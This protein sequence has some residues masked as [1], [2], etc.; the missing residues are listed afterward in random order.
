MKVLCSQRFVSSHI[1]GEQ[2]SRA[3]DRV[4]A[5]PSLGIE[6]RP[7][8]SPVNYGFRTTQ[9][10]VE[11]KIPKNIFF[12]IVDS[13]HNEVN[14]K[15]FTNLSYEARQLRKNLRRLTLDDAAIWELEKKTPVSAPWAVMTL[16]LG[17]CNILDA[18]YTGQPIQRFWFLETIAR[19]PYFSYVAV[20]HLYETLGFW[21]LDSEVK[22]LHVAEETNEC[23]HLM[24]MESLGGGRRWRDRFLARHIGMSYFV[25]LVILFLLAPKLAYKCSELLE[26][27]AVN[28]YE[29]FLIENEELLKTIPPPK[30][31]YEHFTIPNAQRNMYEEK[32][33]NDYITPYNL[34]D[35]FVNIRDDEQAHTQVMSM[36]QNLSESPEVEH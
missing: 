15:R 34:Y 28:T 10:V 25:L 32:V 31:S 5:L 23:Y 30:C 16:Y 1:H 20:Y 4:R 2:T 14:R 27:H 13:I 36:L 19:M 21:S 6:L 3:N 22:R 26:S 7:K 17:I 12:M 9:I 24:I 8:L 18:I 29:Q 35:V 11:D 33:R